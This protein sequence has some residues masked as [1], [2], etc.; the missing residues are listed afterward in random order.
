MIIDADYVRDNTLIA[1]LVSETDD[2]INNYIQR[3]EAVIFSF[4]T[5]NFD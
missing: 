2:V 3:A 5:D 4:I 1:D